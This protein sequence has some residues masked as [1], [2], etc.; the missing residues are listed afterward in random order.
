MYTFSLE[1]QFN[2]SDVVE[3]ENAN[4]VVRGRVMDITLGFDGKIYYTVLLK[5]GD[6]I[7]GVLPEHLRLVQRSIRPDDLVNGE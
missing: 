7:G 6:A 1:S 5:S 2:F 4:E 3:F